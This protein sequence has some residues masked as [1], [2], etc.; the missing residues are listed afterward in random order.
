MLGQM[1]EV[2]LAMANIHAWSAS[3][4]DQTRFRSI[5]ASRSEG[6]HQR[7]PFIID[8]DVVT[9]YTRGII[10]MATADNDMS[11]E[12]ALLLHVWYVLLSALHHA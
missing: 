10:I 6:Q 1:D 9:T 8:L 4:L 5:L 11:M 2:K 3:H 12:R 7:Q